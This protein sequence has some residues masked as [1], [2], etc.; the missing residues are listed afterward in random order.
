MEQTP[1]IPGAR[2]STPAVCLFLALA[3]GYL[4]AAHWVVSLHRPEGPRAEC[5][6][7]R[8]DALYGGL[9]LCGG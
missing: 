9:P 6:L 8:L 7:D 1:E 5:A 3:L 2:P 4:A